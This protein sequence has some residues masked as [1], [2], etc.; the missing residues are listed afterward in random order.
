MKNMNYKII[1]SAVFTLAGIGAAHFSNNAFAVFGAPLN[2]PKTS[3]GYLTTDEKSCF[4]N[5]KQ[6]CDKAKSPGMTWKANNKAQ[7][8][9]HNITVA[10]GIRKNQINETEQGQI[11]GEYDAYQAKY[12][13][14]MADKKI[15][16]DER[17]DLDDLRAKYENTVYNFR[18][19]DVELAKTAADLKKAASKVENDKDV[20]NAELGLVRSR[21]QA[22][23]AKYQAANADGIIS[24][25]ERA[26]LVADRNDILN[27]INYYDGYK[28]KKL[29]AKK[30]DD[31]MDDLDARVASCFAEGK[32]S[33]EEVADLEAKLEDLREE[34]AAMMKS[35]N[36][37]KKKERKA[38]DK[39]MQAFMNKLSG[40]EGSCWVN[41]ADANQ[42]VEEAWAENPENPENKEDKGP[43]GI[44]KSK[45]AK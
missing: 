9:Q 17:V 36:K 29:N 16:K 22:W 30:I 4:V 18:S 13:A 12:T 32:L 40:P 31:I 8:K 34:E 2:A 35:G 10:K 33:K 3:A 14:A 6:G 5:G 11:K 43:S 1:A 25:E 42:T 39:K 41:R 27:T 23:E 37:L 21:I 15:S 45:S 24:A 44:S 19:N 28:A 38:I 20:T 7:M 26:A